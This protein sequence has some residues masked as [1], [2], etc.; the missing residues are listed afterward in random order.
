MV[1]IPLIVLFAIPV[2]DLVPIAK[3]PVSRPDGSP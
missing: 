2:T 1:S 3:V